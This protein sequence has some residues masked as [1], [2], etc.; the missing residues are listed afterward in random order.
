VFRTGDW[1]V[2]NPSLGTVLHQTEVLS[3]KSAIPPPRG[4]VPRVKYTLLT[5]A[6][7]ARRAYQ[8]G[9]SREEKAGGTVDCRSHVGVGNGDAKL[10]RLRKKLASTLNNKIVR[11]EFPNR[12]L[13][14]EENNV[15]ISTDPERPCRSR[16]THWGDG[17][18]L[19]VSRKEGCWRASEEEKLGPL[20]ILSNQCVLFK[21]WRVRRT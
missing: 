8:L 20:G 21:R 17:L 18:Y 6:V 4:R 13:E 2:I 10:E 9:A 5:P 3:T 12:G 7:G 11:R 16:G 14:R 19:K 15:G 1:G